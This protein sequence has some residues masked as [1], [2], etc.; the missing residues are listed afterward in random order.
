MDKAPPVD[1]KK[2]PVME[3]SMKGKIPFTLKKSEYDLETY[4]GR[5]KH[6]FTRIN[7]SLFFVSNATIK[8]CLAKTEKFKVREEVADNIGAKV[9]L[10]PEEVQEMIYANRVTGSAVH[11][12]TKQI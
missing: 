6:Q 8:D 5:F 12:D 9:Y 2:K 4:W 3:D 11:P 1:L 7:P 10:T